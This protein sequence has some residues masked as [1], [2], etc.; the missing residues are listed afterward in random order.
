MTHRKKTPTRLKSL[1]ETRARATATIARLE[2]SIGFINTEL[3]ELQARLHD[4]TERKYKLEQGVVRHHN[5]IRQIDKAIKDEFPAVKP[6]EIPSTFSFRTEYGKRGALRDLIKRILQEAGP[7]GLQAI[8]I[9]TM[10]T[11]HFLMHHNT[12][13]DFNL[14]IKNSL[15]SALEAMRDNQ[16]TIEN[17]YPEG[18]RARWRIVNKVPTWED[19]ALLKAESNSLKN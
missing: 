14:W 3:S 9:G 13:E 5:E 19:L 11:S 15:I 2:K 18:K 1:A 17:F 6:E 16:G 12:K 4:L 10:V 8:E 7:K